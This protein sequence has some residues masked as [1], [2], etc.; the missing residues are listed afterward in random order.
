MSDS[1]HVKIIEKKVLA[2][3]IYDKLYQFSHFYDYLLF[4]ELGLA[5]LSE[6]NF[7]LPSPKEDLHKIRLKLAVWF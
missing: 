2:K 3:K 6:K 4:E 5:P 7:E 1:F